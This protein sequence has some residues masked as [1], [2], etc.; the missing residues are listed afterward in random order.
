MRRNP[1]EDAQLLQLS[2]LCSKRREERIVKRASV[3]VARRGG[4]GRK[5]EIG[6]ERSGKEE[7]GGGGEETKTIDTVGTGKQ[8]QSARA[9]FAEWPIKMPTTSPA[10]PLIRRHVN[11]S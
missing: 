5:G 10:G 2:A 11:Q 1:F 9:L 3:G 4:E 8:G 6:K 7:G